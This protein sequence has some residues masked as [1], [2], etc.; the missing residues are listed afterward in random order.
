MESR[1]YTQL[2]YNGQ[3]TVF[4]VRGAVTRQLYQFS[5]YQPTLR[6]DNRD[7]PGL[8]GLGLSQRTWG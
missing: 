5:R 7:V 1:Y 3:S 6:I 4:C 8:L 2:T